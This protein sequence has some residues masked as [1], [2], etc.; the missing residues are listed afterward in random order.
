MR[1]NSKNRHVVYS[2]ILESRM[3]EEKLIEAVRVYPCLWDVSQRCFKDIIA[4]ENA[5]KKVAE[6][7][8]L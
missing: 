2:T 1:I 6:E 3:N 4:K 5:W 8:I 7:V